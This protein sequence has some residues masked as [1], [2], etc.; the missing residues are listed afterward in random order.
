MKKLLLSFFLIFSFLLTAIVSSPVGINAATTIEQTV[1]INNVYKDGE[2]FYITLK[3]DLDVVSITYEYASYNDL[4]TKVSKLV[5][6]SED[7]TQSVNKVKFKINEDPIAVKIWKIQ[8]QKTSKYFPNHKTDGNITWIDSSDTGFKDVV[9]IKTFEVPTKKI[10]RVESGV[11]G[12]WIQT[13]LENSTLNYF[14][15]VCDNAY[16]LYFNLNNDELGIEIDSLYRVKLEYV[17]YTRKKILWGLHS[18]ETDYTTKYKDVF[19]TETEK[20]YKGIKHTNQYALGPSNK[21]G[22]DWMAL[23]DIVDGSKNVGGVY[24]YEQYIEQAGIINL[25]YV[26]DG[27]FIDTEVL[28]FPTGHVVYDPTPWER[29]KDFTQKIWK[30]YGLPFMNFLKILFFVFI[31]G[32][33]IWII[34]LALKPFKMVSKKNK[35]SKS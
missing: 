31:A 30:N 6:M 25:T 13:V 27:E 12:N 18:W 26:H 14:D 29:F 7:L 23:V 1:T 8:Y 19:S 3:D 32:L 33:I 34:T 16:F 17:Q 9:R 10:V 22:Y 28:D 35:G 2:D 21:E 20:I 15:S 5:N 11:C 4:G 24:T